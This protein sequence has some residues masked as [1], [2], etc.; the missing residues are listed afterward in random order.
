MSIHRTSIAQTWTGWKEWAGTLKGVWTSPRPRKLESCW[1]MSVQWC[2][3]VY[4]FT[5]FNELYIIYLL[6]A[7]FSQTKY[8]QKA[9]SIRFTQVADDLSIKHAKMSQELQSDVRSPLWS[10]NPVHFNHCAHSHT[11]CL[12]DSDLQLAYKA[13]TEQMIHQYTMTKDEPLFRQAKANADLLSGVS[14]QWRLK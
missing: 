11:T 6:S 10:C 3:C 14:S 2:V 5:F 8:R 4:I 1:V 12:L 9:D 13:N 7:F